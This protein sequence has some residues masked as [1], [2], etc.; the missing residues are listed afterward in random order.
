MRPRALAQGPGRAR[1]AQGEARGRGQQGGESRGVGPSSSI[2]LSPTRC[3]LSP[4]PS[5]S[6]A[7]HGERDAQGLGTHP[8]EAA[9]V[10]ATVGALNSASRVKDFF[11][12]GVKPLSSQGGG[13]IRG[14]S[15]SLSLT[16]RIKDV[17]LSLSLSGLV[18][19]ER[20][21]GGGGGAALSRRATP[22][23]TPPP[24]TLRRRHPP[25]DPSARPLCSLSLS[26]RFCPPWWCFF[27]L[28]V[29]MLFKWC[30]CAH[31]RARPEKQRGCAGIF[32]L[33]L[34]VAGKK[35]GGQCDGARGGG[36]VL[37]FALLTWETWG[38]NR[39]LH[40]R[41]LDDDD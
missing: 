12:R 18:V 25:P 30:V 28:V 27:T 21:R 1:A 15:L 8:K 11:A 4:K 26:Q 29:W 38:K 13:E 36:V 2:R 24:R 39:V 41:W 10:R 23:P 5:L 40:V 37:S 20:E 19:C 33:L 34:G 9:G 31:A 32:F 14:G 17:S 16:L 22:L 6:N 7:K 3:A 35:R